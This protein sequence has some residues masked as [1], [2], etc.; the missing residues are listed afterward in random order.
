VVDAANARIVTAGRRDLRVW[1]LKQPSGVLIKALPC[2][3]SHIQPSPDGRQ[4]ALDCKDGNV[5]VW[6]RATATVVPVHAHAG[7]VFGVQWVKGM[8]CSGGYFDGHVV[9]SNP[10]GTDLRTL[11]SGTNRI[12]WMTASPDHDFLVFGSSDG[13]VWR[14]DD[15]LQE[16]YVHNSLYRLAISPDGRLLGSGGFD[17][18]L[19]VYD[20]ANHKL[21]AHVHDH[22]DQTTNVFWV[23]DE[24]W[25]FG[26]DGALKRWVVRGDSVILRH[27]V[28]ADGPM[29]KAQ[30]TRGVWA[31][32]AA[33]SVLVIGRDGDSIALRLDLGRA[34]DAL[35]VSPDQRYVAAGVNGEIV[36][37]DLQRNAIASMTVGSPRPKQ[38]HFLDAATL[39]FSELA[40]LKTV[41]VDHL[42]YVPFQPTNEL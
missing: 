16:L 38:L 18:S 1:E 7:I 42:E 9:C 41:E 13:R 8:I 5:R 22:V 6:T 11:D 27:T 23:D 40:A 14:Y 31:A 4:A 2:E 15:R 33:D 20:L 37:V 24:L 29:H 34:I 35:D 28:N 12:T 39:A 17:G 21:L 36:V 3:V 25:T 19:A 30:T 32:N 26:I 10:D